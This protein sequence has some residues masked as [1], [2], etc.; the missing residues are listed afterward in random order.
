MPDIIN[1]LRAAI[2]A[3]SQQEAVSIV[4]PILDRI[5]PRHAVLVAALIDTEDDRMADAEDG[6]VWVARYDAHAGQV[7][8]PRCSDGGYDVA[9]ATSSGLRYVARSMSARRALR[10]YCTRYDRWLESQTYEV[11]HV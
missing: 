1:I 11:D 6:Q 4:R 2:A 8:G 5:T 3:P 9:P 7:Y 10:A